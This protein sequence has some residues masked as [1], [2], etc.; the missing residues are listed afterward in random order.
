MTLAGSVILLLASVLAAIGG[1]ALVLTVSDGKSARRKRNLASALLDVEPDE[2]FSTVDEALASLARRESMGIASSSYPVLS[3]SVR[4]SRA[5][6]TW[7]GRFATANKAK[8]GLGDDV[9]IQGLLELRVKLCLILGVVGAVM[10]FVFSDVLG[11]MGLAAGF[12]GGAAVLPHWI[13]QRVDSRAA[14]AQ[15][16]LSEMLEVIALGLRSGMTFEKSFEL[17]AEYFDSDFAHECGRTVQRWQSGLSNKQEA[18]ESLADSY[19]SER[20]KRVLDGVIRSLRLGTSYERNLGQEAADARS[21]YRAA[22]E[23]RVA[24]APVKMMVPIGVLIL[25]AMLLLVL[26]PV[27]LQLIGGF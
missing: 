21:S 4:A 20:L 14:M 22:I 12:A 16:H 25:P 2:R 13:R 6:Q 1:F 27:L 19:D 8:A 17:Y 5:E 3:L 24:K 11:L 15:E 9:T 23:E 26:G 18:L 10:G 7:F